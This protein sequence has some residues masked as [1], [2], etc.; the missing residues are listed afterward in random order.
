MPTTK[1]RINISVTEDLDQTLQLLA[2]RDQMPVT[3]KALHL[4]QMAIDIDED[5]I[6]NEIAEKRKLEGGKFISH[7]DAWK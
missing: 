1:K 4:I 3:T 6:F 2:K 7:K 5:E